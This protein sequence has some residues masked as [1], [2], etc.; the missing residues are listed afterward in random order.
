MNSLF[1]SFELKNIK[2]HIN[3]LGNQSDREKYKQV[4]KNIL[5]IN[6]IY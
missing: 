5:Q 4:I 3:S 1:S 6:L 2:L